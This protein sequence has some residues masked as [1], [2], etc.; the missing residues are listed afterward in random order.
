MM[1]VRFS[2]QP[3]LHDSEHDDS[4]QHH[5]EFGR[6]RPTH[7][8]LLRDN[9]GGRRMAAQ[10]GAPLAGIMAEAADGR[11][12]VMH[13]GMGIA[14]AVLSEEAAA[15]LRSRAGIEAVY[16]NQMRRLPPLMASSAED[17]PD[18]GRTLRHAA[19]SRDAPD[20]GRS[21]ARRASESRDGLPWNL[22]LI[23]IHADYRPDGDGTSVAVLDTG[24]DLE[25]PDIAARG[26]D[27]L[28]AQSFVADET[29][30]DANGHG[31]HCAG[32]I[33]GYV[34]GPG[35]R[36]GV[37]PRAR[38]LVGK[39]LDDE[40]YGYDDD[41]LRGILWA[42]RNDA[43]VISMSLCSDRAVGQPGSDLYE[44]IARRLLEEGRGALLVAAAG[45]ASLRPHA[46]APVSDP[47][48][49]GSIVSVGAIGRNMEVADFSP[50]KMDHGAVDI[51]APGVAI[52][53]WDKRGGYKM[54]SG[55]STAC[56]HVAGAAALMFARH[57]DAGA[58]SVRQLLIESA[59]PLG[60]PLDYGAGLVQVPGTSDL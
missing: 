23:G 54:L 30:H 39:V 27:L 37:A 59:R 49:C 18:Q 41:I 16:P 46:T 42:F 29:F 6:G 58:A 9:P 15:K 11:V 60:D 3:D 33:S 13:G 43:R 1:S 45:N 50:R 40:G 26:R 4:L 24:I 32:V 34:A 8:V 14:A 12:D 47:A 10:E 44:Q 19:R 56:P 31:T 51:V 48:C 17:S 53:S 38:L 52:R 5:L 57:A 55:T 36:L 2:R 7:I 20:P 25:H 28:V 21:S 22:G 35:G